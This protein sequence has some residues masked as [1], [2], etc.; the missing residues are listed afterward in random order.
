MAKNKAAKTKAADEGSMLK[1]LRDI[2]VI[3]ILV[4]GIHSC[5]AKP[6]YIPSDSMMPILRNG[7]RLIVS[8]YPYGWSYAS[9]SFHLL[10]KMEGRIFAKLPER[11]D[12]VVLE[13]PVNRADYIKR[14]IGLP[15]ETVEAKNGKV[16]VNGKAADEPY[17]HGY[18][19]PDFAATPV[20]QGQLFLMGDNRAVSLD[21]RSFGTVSMSSIIGRAMFAYWPL[22]HFIVLRAQTSLAQ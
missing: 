15:G 1:L 20:P 13:H 3:L 6:F 2:V 21:S 19:M 17:L 11:G 22:K 9:A 18:V 10:P 14:V 12:I 5:V 16:Y 8:K 7:D 4:L